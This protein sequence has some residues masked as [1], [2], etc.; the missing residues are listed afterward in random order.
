MGYSLSVSFPNKARKEEMESFLETH[1]AQL[2]K[3]FHV[4][5]PN[6]EGLPHWHEAQDD[7][8]YAP[9]R[10]NLLGFDCHHSVAHLYGLCAWMAV[11]ANTL[12][13]DKQPI[14]F[15]DHQPQKVFFTTPP[16]D[17][18]A[19]HVNADGVALNLE[20]F[21]HLYQEMDYKMEDITQALQELNSCWEKVQLNKKITQKPKT[22]AI[23]HK[24]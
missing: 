17:S 8:S 12:D 3:L 10:K 13:K 21:D 15:Y 2:L 11:K 1:Q 7:I 9:K 5:Y 22:V 20:K 14:Y 6:G 19:V 18:H 4:A 24:I 23:P 16:N